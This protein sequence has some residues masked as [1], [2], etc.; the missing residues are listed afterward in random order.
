MVNRPG[1]A[2]KPDTWSASSAP[3][4]STSGCSGSRHGGCCSITA[5]VLRAAMMARTHF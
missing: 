5:T 4:G 2:T 1:C 3:C